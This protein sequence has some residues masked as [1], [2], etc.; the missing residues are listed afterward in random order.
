MFIVFCAS[1]TLEAKGVCALEAKGVCA[2]EAKGICTLEAKGVC[3]LDAK[4]VHTIEAK[5]VVC[6]LQID[7]LMFPPTMKYICSS[8]FILNSCLQLMT[9]GD[10]SR[11]TTG[12]TSC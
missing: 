12:T 4:D 10:G 11:A 8:V 9:F 1:S 3:A 2:L 7:L 5:G 6:F